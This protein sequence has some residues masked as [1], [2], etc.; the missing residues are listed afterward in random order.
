MRTTTKM[1]LTSWDTVED[2]Y[3]YQ[4]LANNWQIVDFHDHSP[5]RGVPIPPGGIG[6]GAVLSQNIA[7]GVVGLQ[8]L[9]SALVGDLGLGGGGRG[10]VSASAAAQVTSSS[11]TVL[12]QVDNLSIQSNTLL[13]VDYQALWMSTASTT[14][15][16]AQIMLS[17]NGGTSWY[18][19]PLATASGAPAAGSAQ[20]TTV[21]TY[22]S[23]LSTSRDG[24]VTLASTTANS[25]EA[26]TGQL[27]GFAGATGGG[28]ARIFFNTAGTYSVGIGFSSSATAGI[29]VSN[30]HLW[31]NTIEF[32]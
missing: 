10:Y 26:N 14:T 25:T 7:A 29:Y 16:T 3:D 32:D 27:V 23:P 24:L 2:N 8:H 18:G 15:G 5:G 20:A 4:Q 21:A 9:N 30:R 17:S 19:V 1:G 6:S 28:S 13:S 11:L 31:V 22:Y 12:D